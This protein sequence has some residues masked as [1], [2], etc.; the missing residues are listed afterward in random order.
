MK[1]DAFEGLILQ[2]P[3]NFK[4]ADQINNM[5]KA[6][7]IQSQVRTDIVFHCD[8]FIV[9]QDIINVHFVLFKDLFK[10]KR[11]ATILKSKHPLLRGVSFEKLELCV[12]Y[13]GL[14]YCKD[15]KDI[16]SMAADFVGC[17]IT[18]FEKSGK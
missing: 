5:L 6:L 4:I 7:K 1:M 10:V 13:F 12:L 17:R 16:I 9:L 18:V 15:K 2:Y 8:F 14:K 3:R 11:K